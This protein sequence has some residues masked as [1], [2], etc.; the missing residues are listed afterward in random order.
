MKSLLVNL[1]LL[2]MLAVFVVT[3]NHR[4]KVTRYYFEDYPNKL[5]LNRTV[6][7]SYLVQDKMPNCR[8]QSRICYI[9]QCVPPNT[10]AFNKGYRFEVDFYGMLK[11]KNQSFFFDNKS[12]DGYYVQFY[13][14]QLPEPDYEDYETDEEGEA[15][16]A[17]KL[18]VGFLWLSS[19]LYCI[20]H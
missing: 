8:P 10:D 9:A 11:L 20:L 2:P 3:T 15:C 6:F 19:L 5:I 12:A 14:R 13:Q 1:F 17:G 18:L 16:R 4:Y 7:T